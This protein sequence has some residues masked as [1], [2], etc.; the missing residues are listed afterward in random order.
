MTPMLGTRRAALPAL[1][2]ACALSTQG[3]GF[4]VKHPAITAGIAAGTLGFAT[5]KLASDNWAACGYVGGGAAAFLGLVTA[6]ALWL[7]G[8]GDSSGLDEPLPALLEEGPPPSASEPHANP[9]SANPPSASPP[10]ASPPSA[11]PPSANPPS[12]NPPSANSPSANPPSA[13]PPD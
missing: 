12:A 6:A 3:C 4:A 9:P 13:N 1:A 10:S 5:C 8:D 11:N 2:M 7:G